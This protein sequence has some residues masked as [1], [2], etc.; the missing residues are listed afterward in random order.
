MASQ[1]RA[2]GIIEG[3]S[4]LP[5]IDITN[6]VRKAAD[7]ALHHLQPMGG[8][9]TLAVISGD[10]GAVRVALE[11]ANASA[12]DYEEQIRTQVF[13]HPGSEVWDLL[14]NLGVSVEI[15]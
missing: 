6:A 12:A 2:I 5:L 14:E 9:I 1:V 3:H 4:L 7:V 11:T 8:G 10:V 13:A 15:A